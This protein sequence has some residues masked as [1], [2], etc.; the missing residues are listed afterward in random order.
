MDAWRAALLLLW[1]LAGGRQRSCA[2]QWTVLPGQPLADAATAWGLQNSDVTFVLPAASIV[3]L[4]DATFRRANNSQARGG[5]AYANGTFT[6]QGSVQLDI[7]SKDAV[8]AA[9]DV[10]MRVGLVPPVLRSAIIVRHAALIGHCWSSLTLVGLQ[11]NSPMLLSA[12]SLVPAVV[13]LQLDRA[14][15]YMPRTALAFN[16]YPALLTLASPRW[17]AGEPRIV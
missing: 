1:L 6:I 15:L 9:V 4:R 8:A 3:S 13:G 11:F 10:G 7:S 12:F 14:F 16:V 2:A 17:T 5:R